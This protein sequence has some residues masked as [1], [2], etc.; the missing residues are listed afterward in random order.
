MS[1]HLL[2]H[3]EPPTQNVVSML[4]WKLPHT[5]QEGIKRIIAFI[6]KVSGKSRVGFSSRLEM[7]QESKERRL[8]WV[9]TVVY[10]Q[11]LTWLEYPTSAKEGSIWVFLS[12]CRMWGTKG[13]RT[14]NTESCCQLNVKNCSQISHYTI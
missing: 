8:T 6:I 9:F 1:C 14:S 10:E 2:K 5:Y 13:R 11:E 7:V 3:I 12:A 4:G